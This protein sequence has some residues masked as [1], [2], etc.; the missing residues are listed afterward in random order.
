[1]FR[2]TVIRLGQGLIT[3]C[4]VTVIIFLLV[5]ATGNPVRGLLPAEYTQADY[6]ALSKALGYDRP[7]AVQFTSFV[8][9]ALHG[10]FGTST[11]Y[12]QSVLSVIAARLPVTLTLAGLAIA[13]GGTAAVL[14]GFVAGFSGSRTL[15]TAVTFVATLGIAVPPFAVG[16]LLIV[17][18]AITLKVVPSGGWGELDQLA[19][20]VATLALTVFAGLARIARSSM[21]EQVQSEFV[22]LA[23]TK[24][25]SAPWIFF[26]HAAR[27]SLPPVV[28]YGAILAGSL[29]SGA[30]VT[31]AVFGIPGLGTLAV[32]AVRDRDQAL[33]I[34]VVLFTTMVFV[35]FN[36]ASDLLTA[37][38]DPRV[39]LNSGAGR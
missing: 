30:T 35:L 2:Y 13:I 20:P 26:R 39:R 12:S 18:F 22:T 4:L 17:I 6:D 5:H 33:V 11:T 37:A 3:V 24:G 16:I 1:M 7:L 34:G 27:P 31:E 9:N 14:V 29:F 38:V 19:L 15:E 21:Q 36:V 23:R 32:D 10:D 28:G 8:G 25:L